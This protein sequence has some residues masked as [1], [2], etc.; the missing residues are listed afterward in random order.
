MTPKTRATAPACRQVI[1]RQL[2]AIID[3]TGLTAYALG[4]DAGVDPGVVQRFLNEERDIRLETLDRLAEV[5]G[6]RLVETGRGR[7]R[8]P[9]TP[10]PRSAR[11]E[12]RGEPRRHA[13]TAAVP[14]DTMEG[15]DAT[16]GEVA[17]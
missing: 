10:R 12:P 6:L 11:V 8:A 3:D 2:R 5:L 13:E 7:S 9:K 15:L 1:T 16:P 4:R 17:S 14:G